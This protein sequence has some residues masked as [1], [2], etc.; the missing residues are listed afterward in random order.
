MSIHSNTILNA[1]NF[2]G[3]IPNSFKFIK[4]KKER[5]LFY[6]AKKEAK[7]ILFDLIKNLNISQT[8]QFDESKIHIIY[9]NID[10]MIYL[11]YKPYNQY[12]SSSVFMLYPAISLLDQKT[13]NFIFIQ[14]FKDCGDMFTNYIH[15]KNEIIKILKEI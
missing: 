5:E 1:I 3:Y 10:I 14:P 15:Y 6:S 8:F 9:K 11:G 4:E 12:N 7:K 2:E 13:E